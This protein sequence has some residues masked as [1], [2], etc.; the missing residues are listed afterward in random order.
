MG[1]MK[2]A[3]SSVLTSL[4]PSPYRTEYASGPSLVAALPQ[5]LFDHSQIHE[6]LGHITSC[7]LIDRQLFGL[8]G[9]T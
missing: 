6:E 8:R 5:D 7:R 3:Y 1:M 9:T 4:R 2:Q